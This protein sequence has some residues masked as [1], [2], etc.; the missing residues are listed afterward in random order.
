VIVAISTEPRTSRRRGGTWAVY[1]CELA[2]LAGQ[3]RIRVAVALCL[4]VPFAF[5]AALGTQDGTPD[6][7]LFGRWVHTSGYAVPLV[8][9][10]FVSQWLLPALTGIVA[11]DL[12]ASEDHFGTWATMLT[13]SRS[14]SEIFAGKTFAAMTYAIVVVVL[15]AVSSLTAGVL[16][17]GD[18]PL[19]DLSGVLVGSGAWTWLVLACWAAVLPPVMAFTAFG[20]LVSVATRNSAIGIAVPVVAGLLAQLAAMAGPPA[21]VGVLLPATSFRAWHGLLT[22]PPYA[23]PLIGGLAVSAAY[24]VVCL[25]VAYA[26]LWRRDLAGD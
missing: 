17:L 14:R 26:L 24:T 18:R 3:I 13:R 25:T 2:K 21:Y 1:R 22:S 6:D 8:V 16:L 7:I 9:L 19:A 15:L 4:L 11:G 12:F 23:G 5:A 20:L 10:G